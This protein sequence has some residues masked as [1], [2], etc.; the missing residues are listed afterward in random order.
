MIPMTFC[1][2]KV[3]FRKEK[4]LHKTSMLRIDKIS[5]VSENVVSEVMSHQCHQHIKPFL[6]L[7]AHTSGMKNKQGLF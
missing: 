5:Y 3:C 4:N 1:P 6:I 7:K 2:T